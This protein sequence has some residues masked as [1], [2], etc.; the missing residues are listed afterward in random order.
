[1]SDSTAAVGD[2]VVVERRHLDALVVVLRREHRVVGPV[3]RDHAI[4]YGELPSLDAL[5]IGWSDQQEAGYY[6]LTPSGHGALFSHNPGPDTWKRE[7][8][9]P[10]ALLFEARRQGRSFEVIASDG[11][12]SAPLALVGVRACELHAMAIQDR[13]LCDGPFADADYRER[14]QRAF[15]V[16][17]NCAQAAP[18]CF[19]TSMAAGPQVE[20]GHDLALTELLDDGGHRFVVEV[21]SERG[22]SVLA[23]LQWR[24][25]APAELAAAAAVPAGVAAA[26]TR[27]LDRTAA[28]AGLAGQPGHPH[29]Q[30]VADRCLSCGNCTA[31]CPTCFCT[32]VEDRSG[33]DGDATARWRRWDSCFTTEFTYTHG[34]CTRCSPRARYRQWLTHKLSTWHAQFGSPGCVG[35]GRCIVWCPVGID[36]TAEASALLGTAEALP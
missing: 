28:A 26:I 2:R 25:P 19:C 17:V 7:L 29:W 18:T 6:R 13:V 24:A 23:Q 22:A 3:V 9:P 14:R 16:A 20:S 32:T 35:C 5:P 11:D 12:V 8:F 27:R 4:V 10:Q 33:L 21:G 36:I 30:A 1:M 31:V 34:H 15:I